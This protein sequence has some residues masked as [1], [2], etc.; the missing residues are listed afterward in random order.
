MSD[1]SE[2]VET[3]MAALADSMD[4]WKRIGKRIET[5][6]DRIGRIESSLAA[7]ALRLR[8]VEN[9]SLPEGDA[10]I[11]AIETRLEAGASESVHASLPEMLKGVAK[12]LT[13]LEDT[14]KTLETCID[15]QP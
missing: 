2:A 9:Q 7:M 14:V 4:V 6:Q 5:Q 8:V 3:M 15:S 11:R 12:R 1:L 10:K 13:A